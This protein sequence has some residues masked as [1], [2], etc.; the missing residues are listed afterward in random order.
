MGH[1]S[2]DR[3]KERVTSRTWWSLWEQETSPR[4]QGKLQFFPGHNCGD[5]KIVRCIPCHKEETAMDID[6]LFWNIIITTCGFPKIISSD[7]DPKSTSEFWTNPYDMLRT[8][9][10]FSTT[11]HPQTDGLAERII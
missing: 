7:R 1:M 9:V 2:E 6:M 4:R 3:T 10:A 8:K 11:Y 5:R